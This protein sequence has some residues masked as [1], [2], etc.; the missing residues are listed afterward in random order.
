[1]CRLHVLLSISALF[2]AGGCGTP[3]RPSGAAAAERAAAAAAQARYRAIQAAERPAGTVSNF[4][5]LSLV[6]PERVENG[7]R[8]NRSFITV[9]IPR[10]P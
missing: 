5:P 10:T 2:F 8:L 3:S 7:V 6:L 4:E 1:M 9:P